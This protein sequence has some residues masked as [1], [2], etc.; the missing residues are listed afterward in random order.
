VDKTSESIAH[1]HGATTE[2]AEAS[3]NVAALL[4]QLHSSTDRAH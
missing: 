2:Q 3:R 4:A 1:I